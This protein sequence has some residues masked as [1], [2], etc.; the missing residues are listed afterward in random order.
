M[1]RKTTELGLYCHIP[2]CA[3]TC[4]FCAFYQEKPYRQDLDRYLDGMEQELD[5]IR[6][7]RPIDTVFWGGGTPSLLPPKDL[8]RLG[9][10]VLAVA[11]QQPIEWTVEMAPSTVK[12]DKL[13]VLKDLEVNRISMGVQSFQNSFLQELGRLHR[14]NQIYKAYDW[15]RRAGFENVNVDLMIALPGQSEE[16]LK[17]DIAEAIRLGPEHLSVY[18]LT[19]EEDTAL[20]AKLS[21]GKIRQDVEKD[22][23]LY[24]LCWKLLSDSGYQHYEISNFSKLGFECIHNLNTWRMKEWIGVGPSAASQYQNF[25]YRNPADINDWLAKVDAEMV[26]REDVEQLSPQSLLQDAIIFGLRLGK[27]ISV[28]ELKGRFGNPEVDAFLSFLNSLVEEDLAHIQNGDR[29][30][31]TLKGKLLA[32][33][34]A[35]EMLLM[36]E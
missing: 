13:S 17:K 12:P 15:I 36:A 25:R 19:F 9:E 5:W 23:K 22:A 4:D 31:L 1:K 18:C 14:P 21:K 2:F 34:I 3:S 10:K 35:V 24:E 28:E 8:A 11:G 29:V 7:D 16:D 6:L 27:G 32:D 33:R 26:N 20:W 30:Y